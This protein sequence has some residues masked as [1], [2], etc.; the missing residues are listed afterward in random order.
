MD[1]SKFGC[2][3]LADT[4]ESPG[5]AGFIGIH[6]LLRALIHD[7]SSMTANLTK[8][9]K[10]MSLCLGSGTEKSLQDLKTAFANGFPYSSDDSRP[11]ILETMHRI[12]RYPVYS[13]STMTQYS[14]SDAFYA[15][16]MNSAEQNYEIYDKELLL[17]SSLLTLAT[18][19]PRWSPSCYR[20]M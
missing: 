6:E 3:E 13:A 19:P 2:S 12:M 8:L 9:F 1:P 20:L 15:R 5:L 4:K 11:F 17:S 14:P 10:R 18:F 7:Y 16:Q